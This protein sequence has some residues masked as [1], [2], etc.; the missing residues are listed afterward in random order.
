ME[1]NGQCEE[2]LVAVEQRAKSNTRR[3]DKLEQDNDALHE[4][5]TSIKVMATEMEYMRKSQDDL[6]ERITVIEDKPAARMEQIVS[7]AIVALVGICIGY[8]FGGVM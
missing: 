5:A 1:T 6:N 7:A 8:L 4:M 2:R 3:I